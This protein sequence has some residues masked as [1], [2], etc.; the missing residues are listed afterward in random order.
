MQLIATNGQYIERIVQAKNGV[1]V[2]ALFYVYESCGRIKARLVSYAPVAVADEVFG[3]SVSNGSTSSLALPGLSIK[4]VVLPVIISF[5][6]YVADF[7]ADFAFF[8]AQPTRAP[9][10]SY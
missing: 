9:S 1:T 6:D 10:I 2:R 8:I 4:N 5:V 7:T 3:A